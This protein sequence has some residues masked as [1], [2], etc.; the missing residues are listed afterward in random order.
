M[1][2]GLAG[3]LAAMRPIPTFCAAVVAAVA[4]F[5]ATAVAQPTLGEVV[6]AVE[7]D[8]YYIDRDA[9]VDPG[10]IADALDGVGD[11]VV[12]VL[13]EDDPDGAAAAADQVR[14]G[15]GIDVVVLV[16]T[17]GEF[18]ASR[19]DFFDAAEIDSAL[20]AVADA[21]D[22]GGSTV[23]AVDA[24]VADL[25]ATTNDD[26][27]PIPDLRDEDGAPTEV[28]P[29]AETA[30]SADPGGSGIGGFLIFLLVVVGLIGGFIWWAKRKAKKVDTTEIDRARAE[31]NSQLEV[32]AH[33]IV[34]YE[35]EI[36]LSGND[37]AIDLYRS[38]SITYNEVSEAVGETDNLLELAALNDK[39]DRARWQLEA[40]QAMAEGRPVPPEPE[41]EKPAA[42]F[43]DPTHKSGTEECTITTSAGD[44]E[45]R[46][47]RRCADQ[48]ERGES[49]EP[50]MI[51]VGGRRVPAAKAPR[52]HGGL[53]MGGLGIFEVILGGL[54]A[55]VAG[56][57]R[58]SSAQ[59]QQ[60]RSSRSSV[61]LDW[62]EMLPKRRTSGNVF[63]P[64]RQPPRPRGLP[65]TSGS[66]DRTRTTLPTRTRTRS[67]AGS[68]R[69]RSR[70]R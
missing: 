1:H 54:G 34:E 21:F 64:D 26:R 14:D 53:G 40:A 8:G 24:F 33:D 44:K 57:A 63:G 6:E 36:D 62:G 5:G 16:V 43:F 10:D 31:I 17:P 69:R 35:H 41:P 13:A 37:E 61:G 23:D 70:S 56:R 20:D 3:S 12:V 29:P 2:G 39:V 65:K 55:L 49:P 66:R 11:V 25:A 19:S 50:R 48:L 22:E 30:S 45:V 58:Q 32:V 42:C 68:S 46:V 9:E 67:R 28:T 38:A 7:A 52:S 59:H 15:L 18:A 51:D 60:P 47:C 27:R 4:V